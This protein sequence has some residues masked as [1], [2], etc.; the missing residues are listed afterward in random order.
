MSSAHLFLAKIT[1]GRFIDGDVNKFSSHK[2]TQFTLISV[3]P[4]SSAQ[5]VKCD[6]DCGFYQIHY[7]NIEKKKTMRK[8]KAE[9]KFL[10]LL[11]VLENAFV[12]GKDIFEEL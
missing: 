6:G 7:I 4:P 12:V 8:R 10:K 5:C 11:I 3:L 9:S 2:L 1:S